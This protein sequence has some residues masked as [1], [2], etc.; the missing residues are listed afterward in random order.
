MGKIYRKKCFLCKKNYI[1]R[2]KLFCSLKCSFKQKEHDNNERLYITCKNCNSSFRLKSIYCIKRKRYCS[3]L[4]QAQYL[5][6]YPPR[7]L[8]ERKREQITDETRKKLSKANKGKKRSDETRRKISESNKGKKCPWAKPPHYSGE[9]CHL[10]RGGVTSRNK[11]IRGSLEY[12]LWRKAV[13]ERD[14]YTCVWCNVK[15]GDGK[16]IYLQADHIKPFA[17]FPKLRFNINNGRTLCIEC[18]RKTDTY[19]GRAIREYGK[20]INI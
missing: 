6:K 4:C 10:W 18:H 8:F 13:F 5:K 15:S 16:T 3:R 20:L 2:G 14:N 12:K 9:K 17:Y 1:G 19:M 11:K 7:Y